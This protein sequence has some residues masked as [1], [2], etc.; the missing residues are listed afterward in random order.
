MVYQIDASTQWKMNGIKYLTFQY[1]CAHYNV[2]LRGRL[3][4]EGRK[5][6]SN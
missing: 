4:S 3:E 1:L 2:F 5:K 6:S